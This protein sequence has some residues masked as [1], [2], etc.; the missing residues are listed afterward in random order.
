[1][2]FLSVCSGIEA[3]SV[4]EQLHPNARNLEGMK[5]GRLTVIRCEGRRKD[6]HL[7]WL[8]AC[9]CGKQKVIASNSLTRMFPVQSCGCMNH[10]RAQVKRK[11][12]GPWNEGKSYIINGGSHCYKTRH[13][14]AKAAVKH[15]G[16][17]C[18]KCGWDKAPCDVHHRHEKAKGGAH[19]IE[20][21]IV[22]CPNC[23]R[24]EHHNGRG[25]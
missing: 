1:M 11:P 7:A 15:Y 4:A 6:N 20:N 23:H 17:R 12:D 14:W 19:T 2:R 10:T 22:L 21:A 18:E 16:N 5:F 8:C 25:A 9:D 3:A 13:G 24:L